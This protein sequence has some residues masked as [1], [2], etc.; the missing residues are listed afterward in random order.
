[1]DFLEELTVITRLIRETEER[2]RLINISLILIED[3]TALLI[4]SQLALE[5]NIKVLRTDH[6]NIVLDQYKRSVEDLARVKFRMNLLKA[7]QR[8]QY[9]RL[10][11]TE[12]YL[13]EH[14]LRQIRITNQEKNKLV[15]FAN[16]RKNGQ[17]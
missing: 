7:D 11:E 13:A 1:M 15:N 6:I 8:L 2:A 9:Q 5:E 3:E 17:K 4:L 10:A 14:K 16:W 12:T